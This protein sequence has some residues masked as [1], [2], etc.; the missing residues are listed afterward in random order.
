M[1]H[2]ML[3]MGISSLLRVRIL[4]LMG[5]WKSYA[6]TMCL[7]TLVVC[8]WIHTDQG[9]KQSHGQPFYFRVR[10]RTSYAHDVLLISLDIDQTPPF[11][12]YFSTGNTHASCVAVFFSN[13]ARAASVCGEARMAPLA[14]CTRVPRILRTS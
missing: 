3:M 5:P 1:A 12:T 9:A 11:T 7:D 8:T 6:W 13:G 4:Y 14:M 2:R 10:P